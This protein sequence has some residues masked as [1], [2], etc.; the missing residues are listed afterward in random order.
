MPISNILQLHGVSL[1][2]LVNE[3]NMYRNVRYKKNEGVS[4]VYLKYYLLFF[5][6]VAIVVVVAILK[7]NLEEVQKHMNVY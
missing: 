7:S 4:G 3:K 5:L 6:A 2:R 1:T